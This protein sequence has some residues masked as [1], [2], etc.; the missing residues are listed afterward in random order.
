MAE[1]YPCC[2][3]NSEKKEAKYRTAKVK[4]AINSALIIGKLSGWK[5]NFRK[6]LD[7]GK[8]QGRAIEK[9]KR[10]NGSKICPKNMFYNIFSIRRLQKWGKNN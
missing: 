1:L 5:N 9:M 4:T 3:K 10:G 2:E 8:G 6:K 7:A